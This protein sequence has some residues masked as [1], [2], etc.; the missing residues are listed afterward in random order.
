M[1]LTRR[2]G[3]AAGAAILLS[4]LAAVAAAQVRVEIE[5]VEDAARDN[6]EARMSLRTRVGEIGDNESRLKRLY[7]QAPDE[8]EQA[9]QPFGYY[10]PQ[11]EATLEG[12]AP[13]WVARF[14]ID[15]GPP[16]RVKSL[17]P[18]FVGEGAD[19]EALNR[20][21]R[22]LPLKL[23]QQLDHADYEATKKRMADAATSNGFLDAAWQKSELR[24]KPDERRA[25]VTLHLDTGPRYFFGPVSIEQ[26]GLKPELIE[27][28]VQIR[29]GDPFEPQALLDLQFRLSDLGYFQSVEIDP[30]RDAANEAREVPV[31]IRTTPRKRAR[32]DFG[33]GYGTDTGA[34]L[35]VASDLRRLNRH[36]HTLRSDFRLSEIKNTLGTT[37]RIPLG[38]TPG[39]S[40]SFTASTET[41]ELDAGDTLKYLI[42]TSL[43]RE[44]SDWKRRLYIEFTHE[45][46]D[47]G[48]QTTTADLLTPG[49]S[50]NRT[51]AD[52]PI[53]TRRGWY[54]FA[55]VHGAVNNVLSSTTFAQ[56]RLLGRA[57]YPIG[58][59]TR[60]IG[61]VEFG[62]SLVETFGDLPASQR[63]FAGGD[64]SVRGYAYQSIGP[65]NEDGDVVGGRFLNVYSGEVEY[66]VY[67]NWG[68]ALFVDAGGVGNDPGPELL[69]GVGAGL[70]YR[71]PIGS[72]QLDLAHPLDDDETGVRIHIGIRVGV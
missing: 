27:R 39:E 58:W 4:L 2:R 41:E 10:S 16:T 8:I 52:N 28:Y 30:Q 72:L 65:R 19:F 18:K 53:Y 60:L 42:G 57:H 11:V 51:V 34:R 24:I 21:L 36:G 17:D 3:L 70:R 44:I 26:E 29:P 49:I 6:I 15:P 1:I 55:D 48:D 38:S 33:I 32:Y 61:R 35:S 43:D 23:D 50:Y 45:E 71:A 37:Y 12:D 68:A 59:R 31:A 64:Q 62:Y 46:S 67:N 20:R 9:L 13:K 47:F 54:L 69:M 25:D 40:L 22:W 63:F 56:G 5:G 66:R 7:R 14:R